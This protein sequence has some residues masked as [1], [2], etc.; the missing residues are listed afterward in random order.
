MRDD[1]KPFFLTLQT[2]KHRQY[3]AL[4][5]YV[6]TSNRDMELVDVLTVYACR[7]AG[8]PDESKK[9]CYDKEHSSRLV[10]KEVELSRYRRLAETMQPAVNRWRV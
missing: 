2:P 5:A 7:C 9:V 8:N 3:E 4:R 6:I 10:G 1:L